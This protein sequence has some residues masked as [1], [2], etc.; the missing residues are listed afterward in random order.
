MAEV[1]RKITYYWPVIFGFVVFAVSVSGARD[2]YYITGFLLALSIGILIHRKSI[3]PTLLDLAI[4]G[5][6]IYELLLL[7][8]SANPR[9]GFAGFCAL[10]V[11]TMY[12]GL[13]RAGFTRPRRMKLLLLWCSSFLFVIS[14]I[15]LVSFSRFEKTVSAAG[16]EDLYN[17]RYLHNSLGYLGNVWGNLLTGFLGI[18][19]LTAYQHRQSKT[20]CTILLLMTIPV[21]W[22]IIRTFSRGVYLAFGLMLG[23]FLVSL[24]ASRLSWRRKL[25]GAAV[26][27]AGLILL[28]A[29]HRSEVFRTLRMTETVSQRRSI[30][31]RIGGAEAAWTTIREHPLTGAGSGNF[32]MAVNETLYEDNRTPFTSIAPGSGLQIPVEKGIIGT[33][34]WLAIPGVLIGMLIKDRRRNTGTIIIFTTLGALALRETT[35]PALLDYTGMQ[36]VILTLVA[37]YRNT[38]PETPAALTVPTAAARWIAWLPALACAG[39]LALQL[40]RQAREEANVRALKALAADNPAAAE[41]NMRA[42][43][44]ALPYRI[45]RSALHWRQ[46]LRTGDRNYLSRAEQDLRTAAEQNPH[47][48]Q[49]T[50]N[51]AV[52]L[53]AAGARDSSLSLMRRLVRRF[54]NNALYRVTLFEMARG[55]Q[56]PEAADAGN[57]AQAIELA[58]DLLETPLWRDLQTRDS[59]LAAA[60]RTALLTQGEALHR[61]T[62]QDSA[63]EN[64]QNPI[65]LAHYGK[66]MYI[67]GHRELSALLLNQAVVQLPNLSKPWCYLGILAWEEGDTAR[68]AEYIRRSALLDPLDTLAQ[69][70]LTT[71]K[72][73]SRQPAQAKMTAAVYP[74]RFLYRNAR[75][76]FRAWYDAMPLTFDYIGASK[77]G[78][79]TETK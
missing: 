57:L 49:L 54:P 28:A 27:L 75:V 50:Y 25:S 60:V 35:F 13:L 20:R 69:S 55:S 30:E 36:I 47:D 26:V 59:A 33:L 31:S 9:P 67:F 56:A 43:G 8:T 34:L 76:K 71:Y 58:P 73:P 14:L 19:A 38:Y 79:S 18:I 23:V 74:Y 48:I 12:Y 41:A 77:P 52:I 65:V 46:F 22:D 68:G 78:F 66:I 1:S 11:S 29:P 3:R 72:I 63:A 45:N 39:I 17:F 53:D 4:A 61:A 42:A 6:W 40:G 7:G 37:A 21:V 2:P 70:Y 64:R 32:S 51:L 5:V 24:L 44:D 62:R 15:A 10:T 16:F